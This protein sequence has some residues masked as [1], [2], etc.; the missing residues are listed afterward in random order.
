[1]GSLSPSIDNNYLVCP[2]Q[3]YHH[4]GDLL[5]FDVN[6]LQPMQII[7]AHKN[8]IAIAAFNLNGSLLAT[9]SEKGTVI[10][11]Y[12]IP[13]CQ[14]R[15]EFR[16]GT[17]PAKICGLFFNNNASFL[18]VTS[19]SE[20]I[21]IF[22]LDSSIPA[23]N[24]SSKNPSIFASISGPLSDALK[25][26]RDFAHLKISGSASLN[27]SAINQESRS[28]QSF[29]YSIAALSNLDAQVL[30]ACGSTRSF[31]CYAI[32]ME[33]GGECTL[34]RQHS[35]ISPPKSSIIPSSNEEKTSNT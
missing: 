16:R 14:C 29:T 25:P 3:H 20:T 21:H 19:D 34:L 32:D 31:Y 22:K 15:F 17:F 6:S 10:R 30:V 24:S 28:L 4:N 23:P 9:A 13:D 27:E 11:V 35:L 8:S 33:K 2:S 5:L 18:C 1:M 12:S 26:Q 7:A